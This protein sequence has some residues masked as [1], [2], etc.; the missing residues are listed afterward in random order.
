MTIWRRKQVAMLKNNYP[1]SQKK[2]TNREWLNA[3][4]TE[5]TESQKIKQEFVCR[6]LSPLLKACDDDILGATY[7][8]EGGDE[9]VTIERDYGGS[10]TKVRVNMD[11]HMA[12]CRDVFR[13]LGDY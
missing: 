5:M 8:I 3:E 11:N 7:D 2:M 9:I 1:T 6:Y 4:Q 12:L 13:A 10:P